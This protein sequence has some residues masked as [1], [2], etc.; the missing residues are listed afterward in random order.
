MKY[1]DVL[2]STCDRAVSAQRNRA[3]IAAL[4]VG[5]TLITPFLAG[6][7]M[8]RP[9]DQ[10]RT[11]PTPSQTEQPAATTSVEPYSVD[12]TFNS[13]QFAVDAFA[14][15]INNNYLGKK[16]VQLANGDLIVAGVVPQ[17][18]SATPSVNLGL[19]RYNAAGQ[20]Q[21]WAN[22]GAYGF[23]GDQYVVYPNTPSP[24]GANVVNV[25]DMKVFGNR[26]FVLI[27]RSF[28]AIDT[29]SRVVVFSTDG[30]YLNITSAFGGDEAEYSGGMAIWDNQIFPSTV[31]IAVAGTTYEGGV[32]RPS[33]R[34]GTVNAD[35]SISFDATVFPNPGNYCPTSRGCELHGI[36]T[37]GRAGFGSPP[38]LYLAGSR[39]QELGGM[40]WDY[41]VM[42][43]SSTGVPA[44]GFAGNGVTT[45]PF[46]IGGDRYDR[47]NTIV[48]TSGL[49]TSND[50]LYL[51]GFTRFGC[52][53]GIG[54]AKL[55]QDGSLDHTFGDFFATPAGPR[56]GKT[57]IGAS[58]QAP[59]N[60]PST[61]VAT[62]G[63]AATLSSDESR[64]AI[65]GFSVATPFCSTPPCAEPQ[66]DTDL[67]VLDVASGT[68]IASL[69]T[70]YTIP[71]SVARARHSGFW[72][73][74]AGPSN[75][76]IATGDVRY[77]QA[78]PGQPAGKQQYATLRFRPD[79]IFANGYD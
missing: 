35:G 54:I 26:L 33:F 18:G 56:T 10:G 62:Y 66:V 57:V 22:P 59:P 25:L 12:S 42:Q 38:R 45:V 13:G 34:K 4:L 36:A 60:C 30:Q 64:L 79:R 7:V 31:S 61:A 8:A 73:I 58:V 72:G 51:V 6:R 52:T 55:K 74:A 63:N 46:D 47:A 16:V 11:T 53:D 9:S 14:G 40:N 5:L 1:S 65:A 70:R 3:G 69:Y 20:R 32:A 75:T 27:D 50:A 49:L 44:T 28:S 78:A 24:T 15:S 39:L 71:P 21:V 37:G 68:A 43:V 48:A 41:L 67:R 17:F 29:D 2:Q 77:F 23:N 19:I 76:F